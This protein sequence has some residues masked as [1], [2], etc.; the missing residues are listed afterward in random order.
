MSG[1]RTYT[2]LRKTRL[3]LKRM[4]PAPTTPA[5]DAPGVQSERL[6][7]ANVR[8]RQDAPEPNRSVGAS[9]HAPL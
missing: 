9:A 5:D 2:G 1:T 8:A 7:P 6:P 3:S 4:E